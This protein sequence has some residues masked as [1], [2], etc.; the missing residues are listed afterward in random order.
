[1]AYARARLHNPVVRPPRGPRTP[2]HI[3]AS[4]LPLVSNRNAHIVR[5]YSLVVHLVSLPPSS[6]TSVRLVRAWRALAACREVHLGVLWRLGAAVLEQTREGGGRDDGSEEEEEG[7]SE[8]ARERADRRAEWLKSCQEGL[9]DRVDKFAEY[10]LALVAAGRIESALDELDGYLD[11]QPYH[12]SILLNTLY[13]QLALASSQP[14]SLPPHAAAAPSSSSSSSS[15]SASDSSDDDAVHLATAGRSRSHRSKRSAKRARLTDQPQLPSSE[16]DYGPLLRAI[17]D[18]QPGLFARA[19]QR[20]RRAAHLEER[21]AQE[22]GHP[23]QTG[24]AARWLALIRT[25][26]DRQA[27]AASRPASP[28]SP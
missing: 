5:L 24:E 6:Q 26:V 16:D 27:S 22:S 14:A 2:T 23:S 8:A 21:A 4:L 1:M 10:A 15:S 7:G 11:N 9:L 13:G 3:P 19:T 28:F 25:H 17:A 20:L 18:E 12:D